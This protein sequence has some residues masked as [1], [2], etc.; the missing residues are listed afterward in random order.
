[1]GE[2]PLVDLNEL[3]ARILAK[4]ES[5]GNDEK[6]KLTHADY[7]AMSPEELAIVA[8]ESDQTPEDFLKG[9]KKL[10]DL[11]KALGTKKE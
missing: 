5:V 8:D 1:M 6:K 9:V 10:E 7:L 4:N 2:K 3:R 11:R